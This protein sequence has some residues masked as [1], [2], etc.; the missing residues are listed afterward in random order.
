MRHSN[1]LTIIGL[2]IAL[3]LAGCQ[4]P[5]T[6]P[7]VESFEPIPPSGTAPLAVTFSWKA[8]DPDRAPLTCTLHPGDGPEPYEIPDCEATTTQPHTYTTAGTYTA[9]LTVTDAAGQT[10]ETTV[11]VTVLQPPPPP[12]N[13]RPLRRMTPSA[14]FP[15]PEAY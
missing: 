15:V 9:T 14:P 2:G 7:E 4:R 5:P 6:P 11:Q 13:P 1:F 10:S 12:P 3:V 8:S